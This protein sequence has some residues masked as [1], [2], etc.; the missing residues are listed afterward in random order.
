MSL[1]SFREKFAADTAPDMNSVMLRAD[2]EL[3]SS[4]LAEPALEAGDIAS[5]F[6]LEYPRGGTILLS[7]MSFVEVDHRSRI[8]PGETL[9]A[10]IGLRNEDGGAL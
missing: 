5:D 8:E 3:I 6:T 7:H 4:N 1:N 9:P 2:A 10:L